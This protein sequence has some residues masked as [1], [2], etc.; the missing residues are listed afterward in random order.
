MSFL[1]ASETLH[2]SVLIILLFQ[3]LKIPRCPLPLLF[4]LLL[5]F[6]LLF[7]LLLTLLPLLLR[8]SSQPILLLLG[9][10]LKPLIEVQIANILAALM[11]FYPIREQH[12][13]I[14]VLH[15]MVV[16]GFF[17]DQHFLIGKLA[18]GVVLHS[19][20][21]VKVDVVVLGWQFT[22]LHWLDPP[23]LY[24]LIRQQVLL[25]G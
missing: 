16:I 13:G 15:G 8:N 25:R 9:D 23:L 24:L 21:F 2:Q 17:D 10:L 11:P 18:V 7:L 6:L 19:L 22:L 3:T 20:Q 4:F 14:T 5:F 12:S 1:A